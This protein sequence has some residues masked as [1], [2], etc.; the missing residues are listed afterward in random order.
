MN[1][2]GYNLEIM[3]SCIRV[4]NKACKKNPVLK[5]ALYNKVD[6][7]VKSPYHFKPL[8]YDFAGERRVHI[9]DSFVLRYTI[10]ELTKTI[11]LIAFDHHDSA[12]RR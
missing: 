10:T 4:I 12:Y 1:T 9:L 11:T 7:I 6:E 3:P 5:N 2:T 8:S